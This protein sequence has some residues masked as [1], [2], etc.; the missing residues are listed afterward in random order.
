MPDSGRG[1]VQEAPDTLTVMA[2]VAAGIGVTVVPSRF[3]EEATGALAY[4]AVTDVERYYLPS[5]PGGRPRDSARW[6]T[7]WT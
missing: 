2:L 7:S 3:A 6:A 5:W 1:S 4:L